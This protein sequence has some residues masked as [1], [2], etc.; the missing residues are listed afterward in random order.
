M[1]HPVEPCGRLVVETQARIDVSGEG[2][3]MHRLPVLFKNGRGGV[4][5]PLA[6]CRFGTIHEYGRGEQMA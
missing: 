3:E 1:Q 4:E 6:L 5:K 2:R